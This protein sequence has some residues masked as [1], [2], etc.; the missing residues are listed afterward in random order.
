MRVM[1]QPNQVLHANR[2]RVAGLDE[3]LIRSKTLPNRSVCTLYMPDVD[4]DE[5]LA[6]ASRRFSPARIDRVDDHTIRFSIH[7]VTFIPLPGSRTRPIPGLMSVEL[8]EGVK[9]GQVFTITAQQYAAAHRRITGSFQWTIPVEAETDLL[10]EEIRKLAVMRHIFKAIPKQDVWYPIWLRFL[11]QVE[12]RVRAFGDDPDSVQPSPSG[13][14]TPAV[15]VPDGA[16]KVE[17]KVSR[18]LYDCFGDFE[19]FVLKTCDDERVFS[20]CEKHIEEVIRK[21][22]NERSQITVFMSAD[23]RHISRIAVH[24]C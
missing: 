3:L 6:L 17:G 2:A 5:I 15:P 9:K 14:E 10:D 21:A 23:S 16:D 22:C 13:G 8:P 20:S 24:C 18:I 4:A 19:G 7:N 11:G 12:D 1:P